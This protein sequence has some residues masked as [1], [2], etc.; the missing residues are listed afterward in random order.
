MSFWCSRILITS[1]FL[2]GTFCCA[3]AQH[4]HPEGHGE[5]L[6]T[7]D[8]N[9]SCS[10]TS[11][12]AFNRA[13]ALLHSFQFAKA[14]EGF[15][16]ALKSDPSCGVAYWGIATAQWSNPFLASNR[17]ANALQSGRDAVASARSIGSKSKREREYVEAISQLYDAKIPDQRTRLLAYRDAMAELAARYPN[18]REAS[19]FYALALSMSE[20]PTD[21]TYASR[22]KAGA[23]LE[24]IFDEQPDHPG[25]AHYIIHSYDVPS[26]AERALKAAIKYS[27]IAPSAPHALHMPSHTFTRIGHWQKSIDANIASA[28]VAKSENDA[29]EELHA[30][31]YQMYAFLQSGQDLKAKRLLA[32][33]PEIFSRFD[34]SV[35]LSGAAPPSAGFYAE[36]AIPARFALERGAWKE[37]VELKPRTTPFPFAEAVTWFARGLGAARLG[38]TNT[39][40]SSVDALQTLHDRLRAAK[41]GYW[42]EQVEIQRRGVSAW[43]LLAV[44][45]EQEALLAMEA[46]ADLEDG[47]EKSAVT[48]GPISPARELLGEML[49]QLKQPAQ[50]LKQF[51]ATLRKEPN[52]FRALAGAAKAAGLLGDEEAEK[53]Y[54]RALLKVCERAD[55]PGRPEL[56]KARV[57]AADRKKA[58]K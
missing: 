37:A 40:K 49:L 44:G 7:V 2:F 11:K 27:M 46:A 12:P 55:T 28:S 22:L 14:V 32:D 13:V 8:F 31:D 57:I 21:K 34:P 23:I 17:T 56:A 18:D 20:E 33:L 50:A 15:R 47:T 36:A 41:E 39:A 9:T 42:A 6:G 35:Q 58:M 26:L 10:A 30:S 45:K 24:K 53:K 29:T 16:T 19:I 5:V 3:A 48:P 51:E 52:R 1:V 43:A 54:Y 38:D 25:L 4:Q